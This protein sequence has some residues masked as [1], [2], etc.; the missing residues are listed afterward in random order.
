MKVLAIDQV[1]EGIGDRSY[2]SEIDLLQRG[3]LNSYVVYVMINYP[4]I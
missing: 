3:V 4:D 2:E 1:I